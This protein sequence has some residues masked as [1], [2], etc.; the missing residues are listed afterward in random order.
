[1][2]P[3]GPF[4]HLDQAVWTP[5]PEAQQQSHLWAVMRALGAADIESLHTL[6]LKDPARYYETLIRYFGLKFREPYT[7][8]VDTRKGQEFPK[9]FPG[10]RLNL[11]DSCL[12]ELTTSD[13][14]GAAIVVLD[15]AGCSSALTYA[16]LRAQVQK[17]ANRLVSLGI[18][19]GDRIGLFMPMTAEATVAF[20]ACA[21][22]GAV[23]VP[24]FSGYG[25]DALATR[26]RDSE[27]RLLVTSSGF[28][29]RGV[30]VDM[31]NVA[32]EAAS[33][34]HN[35]ERVICVGGAPQIETGTAVW[36]SWSH[37][38]ESGGTC[39]DVAAVSMDPN[40]PL[41]LIYTSGTT[42]RPKGIVHSHVGFL[43]KVVS[44]FALAFDVRRGDRFCWITDL[45]WLV[46]PQMIVGNAALGSTTVYYVGALDVP[47][48]EQIWRI[49]E[50]ER[51][52]IVGVSPSAIRGM[53]A[54]SADGPR[55]PHDLSSLRTFVST[56][57]PWDPMAWRWLFE[58]VGGGERPIV[59]YTGG[60]EIAGGILTSYAALP[61]QECAFAGPVVGMDA[62]IILP[63]GEVASDSMGELVVRNIWPGMTHSFWGGQDQLYLDTYWSI[64]PGIWRHG[65][66]A[67]RDPE[68]W[69]FLRG[70]S[71]DTLKVAGRRI[72]P[73]EIESALMQSDAVVEA[74]VVG[75]P[76][77]MKGQAIVAF[78]VTARGM[79]TSTPALQADV[80]AKLG[81]SMVPSKIYFVDALPKTRNGKVVR[82]AIAARYLGRPAGD[83]STLDNVQ[84]LLGIPQADTTTAQEQDL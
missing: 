32:L 24:G 19:P 13:D 16:A 65:D 56:G 10:G 57:E 58:R 43:L 75:V 31:Q 30:W 61:M 67:E 47:D 78:V 37:A 26:L 41:L 23:A 7:A 80:R 1:M 39:P 2:C 79:S 60:T 84:A 12:P 71:D 4:A 48:W 14:G 6:A 22:V 64:Y 8:L 38:I 36:E 42:G 46:G 62:D 74:A 45:G 29:R 5:S 63:D 55:G 20:F 18:A 59:N 21:W 27:A 34:A 66:L 69:W 25:P 15:E 52:N 51:V 82:R 35:L 11:I 83:L 76:D 53:A 9:W 81:A 73:A 68:G 17:L 77:E 70:R 44:D 33:M 54:A 50:R 3:L 28:Q 40:D 72:G 49:C